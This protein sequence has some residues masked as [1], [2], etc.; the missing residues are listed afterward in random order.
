MRRTFHRLYDV[1]SR[2]GVAI[3][4]DTVARLYDA[5]L[6]VGL[7]DAT[8]DLSRPTRLRALRRRL[9]AVERR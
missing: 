7:K 2:S 1:P 6:I 8:A 5:E 4:D 9:R 3:A